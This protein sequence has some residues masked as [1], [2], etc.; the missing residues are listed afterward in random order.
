MKRDELIIGLVF[1]NAVLVFHLY[2]ESGV[3][4]FVTH[5][6]T[7]IY[8]K[9]MAKS[10][11]LCE[12]DKHFNVQCRKQ[13]CKPNESS[14]FLTNIYLFTFISGNFDACKREMRFSVVVWFAG[15]IKQSLGG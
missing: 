9:H 8:W 3:R 2:P 7:K 10:L 6:Y 5:T 4:A 14:A 15:G 11:F 12:A 13:Q 1:Q